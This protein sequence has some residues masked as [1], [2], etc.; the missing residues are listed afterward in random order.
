MFTD[1]LFNAVGA[2]GFSWLAIALLLAIFNYVYDTVMCWITGG[3][4]RIRLPSRDKIRTGSLWKDIRILSRLFWHQFRLGGRGRWQEFRADTLSWLWP[5]TILAVPTFLYGF[6]KSSIIESVQGLSQ[7]GIV[8][9][10]YRL[11]LFKM[12]ND[13]LQHIVFAAAVINSALTFFRYRSRKAPT[14]FSR[15]AVFHLTRLLIID[16]I[17][18]YMLMT[19]VFTW[20]DYGTALYSVLSDNSIHYQVLDPDL[21]YGLHASYQ[22]IVLLCALLTIISFLPAIMLIREKSQHYNW[23]YYGLMYAGISASIILGSLLIYQFHVRLGIIHESALMVVTNSANLDPAQLTSGV[24]IAD[25][26]ALRFFS[27]IRDLPGGFPIP[28]WITFLVSARS[29]L[30]SY[31]LLLMLYSDGERPT[32]R[33]ML[34]RILEV[35]T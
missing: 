34:R 22:V 6:T 8:L 14:W 27:V 23:T 26:V 12:L 7:F 9:D 20:L 31:E 18:G 10:N 33:D 17:L 11:P 32:I 28:S 35:G 24:G 19:M 5:L 21:M 1:Y 2:A 3:L 16:V 13:T 15:S 25:L 30:F 29:I 4:A